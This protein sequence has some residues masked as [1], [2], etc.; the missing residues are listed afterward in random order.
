MLFIKARPNTAAL[1]SQ[2][3]HPRELLRGSA[4]LVK[5]GA[6]GGNDGEGLSLVC[7]CVC[8]LWTQD[9]SGPYSVEVQTAV[10]LRIM[11]LVLMSI[12]VHYSTECLI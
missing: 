4:E 6:G 12:K 5:K 3:S 7:V 11:F 2:H 8:V 10:P 1:P 9:G